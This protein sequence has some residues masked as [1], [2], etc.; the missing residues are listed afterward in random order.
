MY[1]FF[2]CIDWRI[3]KA[4]TLGLLAGQNPY[5]VGAEHLRVYNPVWTLL[6]LSPM[7]LLPAPWDFV[8]LWVAA[9]TVLMFVAWRYKM[10]RWHTIALLTSPFLFQS[11]IIG[12]IDWLPWIGL[13][14]PNPAIALLF[15]AIKPQMTMGAMLVLIYRECHS[16]IEKRDWMGAGW[17]AARLLSPLVG[18]LALQVALFG[19]VVP[20]PV[21]YA[22]WSLF[23]WS[24]PLGLAV[25]WWAARR[26]D[27]RLGALAGPFLTPYLT[28]GSYLATAIAFPGLSWA[29]GWIVMIARAIR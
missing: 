25:L 5:Y 17:T 7:A 22:N 16:S 28:P 9:M 1:W 11:L 4:A 27:V 24:I 13:I 23:P 2:D 20:S 8:A 26:R 29:V 15:L 19:I 12:N 6:L 21:Q 3:F 18:L 10:S 14:I